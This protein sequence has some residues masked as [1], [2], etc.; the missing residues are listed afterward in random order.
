M[1]EKIVH[2]TFVGERAEC[3]GDS[4]LFSRM[5]SVCPLFKNSG[6]TPVTTEAF[7]VGEQDLLSLAHTMA[8]L[9]DGCWG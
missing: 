5:K 8:R 4:C 6:I 1:S 2:M 3:S 7:T 9:S